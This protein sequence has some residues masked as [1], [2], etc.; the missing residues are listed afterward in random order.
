MDFE[1]SE[2]QQA[3]RE[4]A[5]Q[6]AEAQLAPHAAEWDEACHFPVPTLREAA[7][8]GFQAA[9]APAGMKTLGAAPLEIRPVADLAGFIEKCFGDID[10]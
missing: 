6:F 3:F 1:L 7:K 4:V 8:L 5:R 9:Y 2:E 10:G